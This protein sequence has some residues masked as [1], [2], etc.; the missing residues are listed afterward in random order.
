MAMALSEAVIPWASEVPRCGARRSIAASTVSLSLVGVW[1]ETPESLK[2][3][4][5]IVT[6]DR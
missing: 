1:T 6:P 5:P 4:T 3:T 2:A